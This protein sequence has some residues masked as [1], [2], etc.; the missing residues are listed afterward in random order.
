MQTEAGTTLNTYHQYF[1]EEKHTHDRVAVLVARWN[2]EITEALYQGALE[3]LQRYGVERVLRLQVPGSFE[4]PL[5]ARQVATTKNFD[6][7]I[8]LGAVIKGETRH[9]EYINHA[10]CKGLMD[11]QLKFKL[12]VMMGVLTCETLEQAQDRAGGKHGN[13]GSECAVAALE[14]IDLLRALKKS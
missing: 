11:V 14:M 9:D 10:V 2:P 13:K 5:A 7:I 1:G 12:P 4:L 8:C 3:T 6:A